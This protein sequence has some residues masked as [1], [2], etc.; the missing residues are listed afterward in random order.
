MKVCGIIT[1]YNPLH[2]GHLYHI[3]QAR[4]Q[5]ECD[6]LIA[7][8]SGNFVQRGEPA[9]ID[10]WKR[11]EAAI[12]NGVDAVIELPFVYATQ[13]ASVFAHGGVS[14]LKN[15]KADFI[16]FGSECGNLENLIEIAETS[17]NPDHLREMMDSGMSYPRAYSLLTGSMA[18]NDILAVSYLKEMQSTDIK[19]LIV[20]RTNEYL[21]EELSELASAYAIRLALKQKRDI[22][23]TTP[24]MSELAESF[25]CDW[26][27][28]YPYLRTFLLMTPRET[29][30]RF[31]MMSEGIEVHLKECASRSRDW[32]E[33]LREA[34]TY[35]YT[36]SRIRRTCLYALLQITPEEVKAAS[37]TDHQRILAF[38]DKGRAWLKEM[39]KLEVS[40]LSRF[41]LMSEGRKNLE[42][43]AALLYSSVMDEENRQKLLKDEISGARYIHE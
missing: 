14:I 19:P 18:P 33:F 9:V 21:S 28:Y 7:V 27:Q 36:A 22:T 2:N 41:A 5:S 38:N 24:M 43:R 13:S 29:L 25:L 23:G 42:Y 32:N 6:V 34:V 40:T 35:R 30:C 3:E 31:A 12:R 17:V 11:A 37:D 20:E 4:K 10:K 1:E 26:D 16:C 15:A 8:M 39:K